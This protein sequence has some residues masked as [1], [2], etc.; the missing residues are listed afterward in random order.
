MELDVDAV[1]DGEDVL[2]G[3]VMEHVESAG[4]HSGD[5]ACV[6]PRARSTTRR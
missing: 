3:G 5:S 6:I 1:S 2:I 4:V